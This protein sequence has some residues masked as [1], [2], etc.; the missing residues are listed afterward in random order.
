M[1][2]LTTENIFL[3]LFHI[4]NLLA[5]LGFLFRNQMHL[6]LVMAVSL[7]LQAIYY[8]GLVGGPFFDPL[9]WKVI[10]LA[11]NISMIV[12]LFSGKL[13]YGIPADLRGLFEK[14][15]VLSPG[16]FRKLIKESHRTLP[17][18]TPLLV[19][20]EKPLHLHYL[21]RGSAE[22]KKGK[23]THKISS[24]VFLGEIAFL[25]SSAA[26]ATVHLCDDAECVSWKSFD[27]KDTMAKDKAI[28]IA[29]RGIFNH[30]LAAKV[31]A[32]VPLTISN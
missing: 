15:N 7:L 14:I 25:N 24:G 21:L 1:F 2:E 11:A 17:S 32:S 29:M 13:D 26:T 23:S 28:D 27:L 19:E 10:S 6:R 5:F 12:I 30:D 4:S 18:G 31:A 9:I 20:G 22:I 3:W 16:Q 8:Y